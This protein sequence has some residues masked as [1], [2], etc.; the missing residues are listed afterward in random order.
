MGRNRFLT[1]SSRMQRKKNQLTNDLFVQQA[2][3]IDLLSSYWSRVRDC[4]SFVTALSPTSRV[5]LMRHYRT[6]VH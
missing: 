1:K 6:A 3:A 5:A 4:V 2:Q